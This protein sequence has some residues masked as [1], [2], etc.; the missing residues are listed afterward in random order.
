MHPSI[1]RIKIPLKIQK[2]FISKISTKN[3]NLRIIHIYNKYVCIYIFISRQ[4]LRAIIKAIEISPCGY[5]PWHECVTAE[6]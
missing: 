6:N 3:L 4:T 1:A 5:C 2:N